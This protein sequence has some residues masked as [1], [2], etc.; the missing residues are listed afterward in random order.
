VAHSIMSTLYPVFIQNLRRMFLGK[1]ARDLDSLV[2]KAYIQNYRL[3]GQCLGVPVA[4]LEF[5]ILDMLGR[6]AGKP[7][8]MLIGEIHKTKIGYYLATEGRGTTAEE[9]LKEWQ[10]IVD[11]SGAKEIKIR[12]GGG[13]MTNNIDYPA[14]RTDKLIPLFRKTFGDKMFI[15]AD[16]NGSYTAPEA[17]RIGKILEAY[18]VIRYEEPVPYDYYAETK[19]VADALKIPVSGGEQEQSFHQLRW[20]LANG[21]LDIVEPDCYYFGGMIRAT[22]IARIAEACGGKQCTPH[23]TGGRLGFIYMLHF[24][25]ALPNGGYRPEF[26]GFDKD[27]P[28]ECKSGKLES[29]D[30]MISVPTGLGLGVEIDPEFIAKHKVVDKVVF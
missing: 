27:I 23:M 8:G 30:G 5:A 25:S 14:G 2:D 4:T 21:G 19:M 18:G 20:L 11:A 28:Y 10:P 7:I 24:V 15:S 9:T 3:Q 17:I 22:R 26:K 16:S 29:T 12:I 13:H 6:I 1:D